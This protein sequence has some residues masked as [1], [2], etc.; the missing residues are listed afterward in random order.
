MLIG[1]EVAGYRIEAVIGRGGMGVVYRAEHLLLGRKDAL[2]VLAAELAEDPDFR[3]RFLRESRLAARIEHPSIIPIYHAGEADGLLYIAMRYV[4]GIDL[5]ALIK[6]EGPLDEN[7]TVAMLE[8]VASALDDAHESGLV[9]R[10]V[11]PANILIA[12]RDRV[13]L[14]DFGIAKQTAAPGL[15]RTGSF[16]GTLDYAAPEQ[17]EGRDLDGR[18]DGYSLG[19]VICECLT[20]TVPYKKDS[21]VQVLYAHLLEPPPALTARRPELG[22]EVDAVIAKSLAKARDDRYSSCGELVEALRQALLKHPASATPPVRG[23]ASPTRAAPRRDPA[24]P[25][26]PDPPIPAPARV[27]PPGT[28][29]AP[30]PP[31]RAPT[32][33]ARAEGGSPSRRLL[34]GAAAAAVL[35]GG[36]AAAVVLTRG[37]SKTATPNATR[38][39]LVHVPAAIRGGCHGG[40]SLPP[41][42][43]ASV[44]CG[45][46]NSQ[47]VS[48]FAFRDS[49]SMSRYYAGRARSA[50]LAQASGV[51][52]ED[53]FRGEQSYTTKGHRA[54]RVYCGLGAA[55]TSA[56]VGWTDPVTRIYSRASR[57]D[58]N[59]AALASWWSAAAGP[60][61]TGERTVAVKSAKVHPGTVIYRDT[62]SKRSGWRVAS[63]S[64]GVLGYTAGGYR[65]LL[66]QANEVLVATTAD[67]PDA[68]LTFRDVGIRVSARHI[69]GPR[70]YGIGI[71]C[72]LGSVG[73]RSTFYALQ[74]RSDGLMRIRKAV[75]GRFRD[76]AQGSLGRSARS[77]VELSAGCRGGGSKPVLLSL[78]VN[79]SAP[80]AAR[81]RSALTSGAVGVLAQS[82]GRPR[83]AVRF[84][85][86][87]VAA[88]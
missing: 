6:R 79:G 78:S 55:G 33:T 2:K 80:L 62:F 43:T 21:E 14:S 53:P 7:R 36:A 63:D 83:V 24:T 22:V 5:R 52:G 67:F 68:P 1:S 41:G 75:D 74:V 8:Q 73:G 70:T 3:Q 72:L 87:R 42:A 64:S 66:R 17:I 25:A 11:K 77:R 82:L 26:T 37:G 34:V 71:V 61:A 76:L 27:P 23:A 15:T 58:G 32:S 19:C 69:A 38:L 28:F 30:A 50:G 31:P 49:R 51:C 47:V 81:D 46:G 65:I 35:L 39:L 9:H 48:Y 54:G 16:I 40:P 18:A 10:D 45:A 85:D 13:Y 60:L 44:L 56:F 84:D 29:R 86:F 59:Q 88:R 20:G 12:A 57:A 4:E